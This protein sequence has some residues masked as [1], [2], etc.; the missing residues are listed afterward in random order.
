[1]NVKAVL[2][3]ETSGVNNG[4]TQGDRAEDLNP[5]RQRRGNLKRR[6]K[7]VQG[8]CATSPSIDG[9]ASHLSVFVKYIPLNQVRL[10]KKKLRTMRH[11]N[12]T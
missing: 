10:F 4:S 5:R 8:P 1:M 7:S 12:K 3:F 6:T 2:S 11:G 9:A